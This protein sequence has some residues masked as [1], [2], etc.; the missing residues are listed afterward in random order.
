MK[1]DSTNLYGNHAVFKLR[2]SE[3]RVAMSNWWRVGLG[4]FFPDSIAIVLSMVDEFVQM[5]CSG[6]WIYLLNDIALALN[7]EIY[8]LLNV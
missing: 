3:Q 4:P 8:L 2:S 5:W 7:H 1:K 6:I